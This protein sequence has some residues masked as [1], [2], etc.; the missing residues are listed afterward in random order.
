M[1]DIF[2][3]EKLENLEELGD[4]RNNLKIVDAEYELNTETACDAVGDLTSNSDT[5][6]HTSNGMSD[7]ILSS[8]RT[9]GEVSV[10]TPLM[11]L[12]I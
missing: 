6:T 5:V 8:C 7:Q 9:I 2:T 3:S 11:N 1:D 12:T 4:E 10:L